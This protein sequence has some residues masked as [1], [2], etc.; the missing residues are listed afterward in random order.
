MSKA[1]FISVL[2]LKKRSILDGNLDSDKVIQFI[3]VAQDTHIQNYLGGKLYQ[4]L[5]DI[6]IAGTVDESVNSDYKL[7][8]N[9]YIKPMLIW[10]AQSNFL[11]FAMYQISNGGV[12]KH[13]S[14]NSDAVTYE[15]MS[16]L[17]NRVSETA[18]FYTRRFLDYMSYNSTLYPEYTSNS[19]DDMYPDKDVN[20][21]GWVL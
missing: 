1:L 9:T 15:E 20:F 4:K 8:L 14:E 18:D 12:F 19:N 5:Q 2:D 10:Y 21:H 16:M 3:E 13:R 17:I 11:P 6:I 7:L